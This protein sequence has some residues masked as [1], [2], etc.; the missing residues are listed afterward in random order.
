MS[1]ELP[2]TLFVDDLAKLL[3]CSR[4][5]ID[6]RLRAHDNLPP[7]L[8]SIDSRHRWAREAVLEWMRRPGTVWQSGR[9]RTA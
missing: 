6:R 7:R 8:P 1:D 2:P 9:R 5:T 3:R 4:A